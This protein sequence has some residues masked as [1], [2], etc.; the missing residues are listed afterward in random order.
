[1]LF[2]FWQ[3]LKEKVKCRKSASHLS[4]MACFFNQLA[5]SCKNDLNAEILETTFS[6]RKFRAVPCRFRVPLMSFNHVVSNRS[7][8]R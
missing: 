7:Q 3:M 8:E 1:M 6:F 5:G 4:V 2:L